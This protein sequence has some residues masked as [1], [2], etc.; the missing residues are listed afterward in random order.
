M[1]FE[2]AQIFSEEPPAVRASPDNVAD[3]LAADRL[4]I[5]DSWARVNQHMLDFGILVLRR[6]I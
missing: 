1:Q 6:S 5:A 3:P 2:D 4:A